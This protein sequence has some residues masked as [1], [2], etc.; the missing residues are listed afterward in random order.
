MNTCK[1]NNLSLNKHSTEDP[2]RVHKKPGRLSQHIIIVF[3][4]FYLC[5]E[6]HSYSYHT[7]KHWHDPPTPPIQ[8]RLYVAKSLWNQDLG[9]KG[10][11]GQLNKGS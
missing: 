8:C 3:A 1:A 7:L 2:N 4:E 10:P 6:W 11:I 9:G 5:V